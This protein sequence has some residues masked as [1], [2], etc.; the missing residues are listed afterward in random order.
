MR[1]DL[2]AQHH[3]AGA[4]P[5]PVTAHGRPRVAVIGHVEWVEFVGVPHVP[6]AGEIVQGVARVAVAAGGG[7]VAAVQLA[8]WGAETLFFTAI[9][10]DRTGQR[11]A[12]ELTA[13]GVTLHAVVRP[14]PQRRAITMIDAQR[15]RTILLTGQRH[16]VRAADP[17]PWQLLATCDAIYVTGC[18]AQ[19]LRAA[20]G[21]RALV[22]TSR[23]L[24]LL[25]EAG[26]ELDALVGSDN[27]PREVY[28]PGDLDPAPRLVVRTNGSAGGTWF[29]DGV[30][31][32]YAPV[33]TTVTGD[34]YGAGDTFAAALTL[35][36]GVKRPYGEA[37][38]FAAARA[39][40]VLA[41]DGP[42]PP[43]D[44]GSAAP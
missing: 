10:D 32:A 44:D 5:L 22:A 26:V 34:T 15:E 6:V 43:G 39:A 9:G 2:A 23:V 16:V 14:A 8:R 4:G 27:D 13:H 3:D 21:A 36:L 18:D 42:Y 19:T 12:A 35:A 17:L 29:A 30:Q 1:T 24:P 41:Y 28:A 20:R 25:R 40:E 33:P 11:A 37:I 31:H 7:G 38:E